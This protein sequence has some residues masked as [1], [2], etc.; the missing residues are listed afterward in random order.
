MF[1]YCGNNPIRYT[2]SSGTLFKEAVVGAVIGS[3]TSMALSLLMGES[4]EDVLL[5]TLDGALQGAIT[6][7]FTGVALIAFVVEMSQLFFECIYS[8]MSLEGSLAVVMIA[9]TIDQIALPYTGDEL[10]DTVAEECYGVITDTVQSML[11]AEA[12]D[13]NSNYVNPAAVNASF[14]SMLSTGSG[15]G[16]HTMTCFDSTGGSSLWIRP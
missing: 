3:I 10:T 7:A 2:D 9:G 1:A 16:T 12:G 11:M 4:V 8:G 13:S 6:G 14:Y 5:A 15:G